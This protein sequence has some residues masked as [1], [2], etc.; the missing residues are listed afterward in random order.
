[1]AKNFDPSWLH[2]TPNEEV[3]WA[4]HRSVYRVLP[5]V[6]VGI[7]LVL[8]GAGVTGSGVLG[9]VGWLG[10]ILIPVGFAIAIPPFLR[11]RSEWYVLT[12]EEIYHKTGV[13]GQDVTQVR[14]DRIQDTACS[15][16][17][18]ER[19]FDYGDV[20]IHTA[21]SGTLDLVFEN[22]VDP[23]Q[24]NGLLTEQLDRTSSRRQF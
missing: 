10:L 3:L 21:G 7:L 22:V 24:V 23:Q 14:L 13:F 2:L 5:V 18:T 11:W 20:A 15:Q 17:L 8:L 4:G 12:T 1:M 6:T 16:S 19:V 9:G